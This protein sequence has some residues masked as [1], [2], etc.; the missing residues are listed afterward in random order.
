MNVKDVLKS[1]DIWVAIFITFVVWFILPATIKNDLVLNL[2]NIGISVLSIV[3]SVFFAALAIIITSGDNDFIHFLEETNDY[4]II[5]SGFKLALIILFLALLYSIFIYAATALWISDG[6][7]TQSI[8]WFAGFVFWFMY[9][10]MAT[11]DSSLTSIRY[12]VYR[13]Q[14]IRAS[15]KKGSQER[16]NQSSGQSGRRSG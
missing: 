13:V 12:A 14:F 11:A 6:G 3:F 15:H 4:S 16:G 8:Y 9:G 5:I 1:W 7:S 2:Y 10:L